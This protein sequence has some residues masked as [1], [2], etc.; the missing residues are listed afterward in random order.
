MRT[1]ILFGNSLV[2]SSVGASLRDR[3]GLQLVRLDGGVPDAAQQLQALDP[4]VVIFDRATT[5]PDFAIELLKKYP[6]LLLI[7]IDLTMARM[8][9][10]S[11]HES[12]VLT[13]ED[14]INVIEK[15]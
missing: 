5:L 10:L 6:R 4:D 13:T 12:S 3:A 1:V 14:L 11:G 8:L 15:Q 9:V 2:V 7:G